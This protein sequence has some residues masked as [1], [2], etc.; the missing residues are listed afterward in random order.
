MVD[1]TE[2]LVDSIHPQERDY[3]LGLH[4]DR[5]GS[6]LTALGRGWKLKLAEDGTQYAS[7]TIT[8]IV[9]NTGETRYVRRQRGDARDRQKDLREIMV[10]FPSAP[11]YRIHRKR[12]Y[13]FKLERINYLT[14]RLLRRP[15]LGAPK[16]A[17]RIYLF[18]HGLNEIGRLRFY[19]RLADLLLKDD[20][21][22][23]CIIR[24]MPGHLTRCPF[25]EEYAQ[26][27]LDRYLADAGDL[28]RQFLRFMVETQWLLSAL[29]PFGDY[30]VVAGLHLLAEGA[31]PGVSRQD[32]RVLAQ[33]I[34]KAWQA[35]YDANQDVECGLLV[36]LD[37]IERDVKTIRHLVGW[38]GS[39]TI[40]R[41]PPP[42]TKLRPP[43]L[44]ALGYSMGGY[45]AQSVFFTWPFAVS[46]CTTIGSGGPL[47]D[48]ALTTFAH[49]E[50]WQ[51][52][53]YGL[54]FEIE[55]AMLQRRL[56]RSESKSGDSL[57]AGIDEVHYA[58]FDR[59]F[60]DVFLQDF[61]GAYRQRVSEYVHRLLFVLGGMDPV[62]SS[63]SVIES[64]PRQGIN[65][66]Q[67]A[68][69][70]HFPWGNEPEWRQFWLPEVVSVIR[71]FSHRTEKILAEALNV[72]WGARRRKLQAHEIPP[73]DNQA[74][75][76]QMYQKELDSLIDALGEG[77]W[78]FVFRKQ[79]P[80]ALLGGRAIFVRGTQ[81]HYADHPIRDDA[82]RLRRRGQAIWDNR[83]R[84]TIII[85]KQEPEW[86]GSD[87]PPL[88]PKERITSRGRRKNSHA[89]VAREFFAKYK[90]TGV[91]RAFDPSMEA[92]DELEQH[93]R[94]RLWLSGSDLPV[95]NFL[96]NIWAAL[97]LPAL[98]QIAGAT[99]F[100]KRDKVERQFIEWV[101]RLSQEDQETLAQMSSWLKSEDLRIIQISDAYFAN[102]QYFGQRIKDEGV[103]RRL[104]THGALTYI[105]SRPL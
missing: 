86:L 55:S 1:D 76:D 97:T 65:M 39:Q 34:H 43:A 81:A 18:H 25:P 69:L 5:W 51:T 23:A 52:V 99:P 100:G 19:Y 60:N 82:E 17:K 37:G 103:A 49:P 12:Q 8:S 80:R 44:H 54:R 91:L 48:V 11:I 21:E 20:E 16:P 15:W 83:K 102:A 50:E 9:D 89:D 36:E 6:G 4:S 77:G 72:N 42:K 71:A 10:R 93:E 28:L 75:P 61:R 32:C 14:M 73:S 84:V 67:V 58:F 66:I 104:L 63:R 87:P 64:G 56:V 3:S 101:T 74:L 59:I 7:R 68:G 95:T 27:P 24:P 45:L 47:R 33:A 22:A 13:L 70:S 98:K 30:R 2:Y 88:S 26:K 62:I 78:L 31:N 85:P 46:S 90:K 96:P 40:Q 57:I 94:Q 35:A 41:R 53:M 92:D 29:V 79:V 38:Q 105:L